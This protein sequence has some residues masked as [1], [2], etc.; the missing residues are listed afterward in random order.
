MG[1]RISAT[2]EPVIMTETFLEE[3]IVQKIV[4]TQDLDVSEFHKLIETGGLE[5]D[6]VFSLDLEHQSNSSLPISLKNN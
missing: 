3:K 6:V 4:S 5:N 2:P 1:N